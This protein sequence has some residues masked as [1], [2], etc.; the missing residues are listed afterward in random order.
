LVTLRV[1]DYLGNTATAQHIKLANEETLLQNAYVEHKVYYVYPGDEDQY[2][3]LTV[4]ARNL[5]TAAGKVRA[6]FRT[7]DKRSGE[8]IGEG[9]TVNGTVLPNDRL[10][11]V[12]NF[13]PSAY[14]W[15]VGTESDFE[16]NVS[17]EF[18]KEQENMWVSAD[19]PFKM[20]FK[21]RP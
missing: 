12:L 19:K 21:V 9:Y 1:T 5:G 2:N 20:V 8:W 3:T 15:E 13:K 16:V 6:L 4:T 11:L 18:F 10:D 7:F 14:G 17:L